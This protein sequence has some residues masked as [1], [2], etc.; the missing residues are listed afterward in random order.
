MP[1]LFVLQCPLSFISWVRFQFQHAQLS[2]IILIIDC[3]GFHLGDLISFFVELAVHADKAAAGERE[4]P[5]SAPAPRTP[6]R[7]TAS[8]TGTGAVEA[9]S[10]VSLGQ[11]APL[12]EL[13]E[14]R[15]RQMKLNAHFM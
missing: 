13:Y 14:R 10:C 15:D 1:G 4:A 8:P 6:H 3:L 7:P 9:A 11:G 12:K 5:E 2:P